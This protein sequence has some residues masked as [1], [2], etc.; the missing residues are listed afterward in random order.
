MA[1]PI[2]EAN[3]P[4]AFWRH[5]L[6]IH[7]FIGATL[8][9]VITAALLDMRRAGEMLRNAHAAATYAHEVSFSTIRLIVAERE[10]LTQPSTESRA[11]YDR[12][13]RDLHDEFA[14]LSSAARPLPRT[15]S[16][17][18]RVLVSFDKWIA[19]ST[20]LVALRPRHPELE[21]TSAP[22]RE[23]FMMFRTFRSDLGT[24]AGEMS[25]DYGNAFQRSTQL[26]IVVT[27]VGVA[28][29]VLLVLDI[30][31]T[32]SRARRSI[33]SQHRR[34]STYLE[35][36]QRTRNAA[37]RL[38]AEKELILETIDSGVVSVDPDGSITY[39]NRAAARLFGIVDQSSLGG[40]PLQSFLADAKRRPLLNALKERRAVRGIEIELPR[41]EKTVIVSAAPMIDDAGVLSGAVANITDITA[42]KKM[43]ERLR[44]LS[45]H[46]AQ[47][48]LSNRTYLLERLSETIPAA[49]ASRTVCGVI[50]VEI[51]DV[52]RL[53]YILG[54]TV[55]DRLLRAIVDRLRQL[56]GDGEDA[57][58]L[59]TD[60]FVIVRRDNAVSD[61]FAYVDRVI[62][63][64]RSRFEVVGRELYVS[65]IAGVSIAP[66]DDVRAE[67]LLRYADSA[68]QHARWLGSSAIVF[69]TDELF[70]GAV[71][72]IT[73]E[74]DLRAAISQGEIEVV[75]QP[76]VRRRGSVCGFEALA[77][78]QHP[79]Y[80]VI[81]P[82]VFIPLSEAGG[83]IA[84]LGAKL[85][86]RA[87]RECSE[88]L[89]R[90]PDI[91]LAVNVSAMQLHDSL[92]VAQVDS[93]LLASGFPAR[94]LI[95]EVTE[96]AFAVDLT[97]V[98]ENLNS[99]RER[100]IRVAIDDFGTGYGSFMYLR[101]FSPDIIKLDAQFVKQGPFHR[102]SD[103]IC[104]A[105]VALGRALDAEIVAEGIEEP[106]H[107]D[108]AL[109]LGCDK[110]QG[111]LFGHPSLDALTRHTI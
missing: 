10:Y 55:G 3:E 69:Y 87:L 58:R 67:N 8:V 106:F 22:A 41:I 105:I 29:V 57:A 74:S 25:A 86:T 18:N 90:R 88:H 111:F 89:V 75:Y 45:R 95:F 21:P 71:R 2:A 36:L 99:S 96:T 40:M 79:Q 52:K 30:V 37:Q 32:T 23:E 81:P 65:P 12:A 73:L 91:T 13:L 15:R 70:Q 94:Q 100:G 102:E 7:A 83:T 56:S 59:S 108:Y 82:D 78:W 26:F 49:L 98:A 66:N 24:F 109:A 20:S 80:G 104:R 6:R 34:I 27:T 31:L 62:K 38:A 43:E 33:R 92:F 9:F 97:A 68:L 93:A 72:R 14:Q 5:T 77:R 61:V 17:L 19:K 4:L 47:T 48:G 76:I 50:V 16:A 63:E 60:Q 110:L 107:A 85:L 54:H 101:D 51:E 53:S 1:L 42:R 11:E 28:G 103:A 84:D 35:A 46:D 44:Y 39:T 64:L